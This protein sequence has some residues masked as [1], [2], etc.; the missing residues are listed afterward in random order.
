MIL[1][2]KITELEAKGLKLFIE[3]NGSIDL[4]YNGSSMLPTIPKKTY[5]HVEKASEIVVGSIYV[6]YFRDKMH[7]A[8]LV[9]HRLW[10]IGQTDLFFKGDNR[11]FFEV[12]TEDDI[13]GVVHRWT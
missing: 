11:V 7:H 4:H 6:F 10:Q 9:C 8:C 2:Q 13:I 3:L 1:F 12:A 5:I